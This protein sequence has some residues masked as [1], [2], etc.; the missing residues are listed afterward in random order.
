MSRKIAVCSENQLKLCGQ[1]VEQLNFK[2][3]GIYNNN[4]N[5]NNIY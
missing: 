3:G 4:N 5:N 1:N 2:T